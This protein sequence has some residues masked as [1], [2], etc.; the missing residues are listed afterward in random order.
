MLAIRRFAKRVLPARATEWLKQ[1]AP[2]P[3]PRP[4]GWVDLGHLRRVSPV[5]RGFGIGRGK[6]L[7]RYYIEAFLAKHSAD[8]RGRVLEIGDPGY[9]R[10]F[11]ADRVERS[12][13]LHATAGNPV[14]TIVGDLAS[15]TGLE[16]DA[17]DCVIL[18]Q[19]LLLIYDVRAAVRTVF[20]ILAPGGVA[21]VTVPGISQIARNDM[22]RYGDFWRF[23]DLSARRL[24]EESFPADHI[25][26]EQYGNVLIAVGFLHGMVVEEL[27]RAELDHA[28]EDYPVTIALRVRKPAAP[29]TD[30]AGAPAWT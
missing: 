24:F 9:T 29:A 25:E 26:V 12:D 8:V 7:D 2:H 28:D 16:P 1:H 6:P 13:V 10:A 23:T 14:A 3:E 22:R 18:T 17:F 5:S 11:G 15:G 27:T 19:T 4:V 30:P 20:R 21:L